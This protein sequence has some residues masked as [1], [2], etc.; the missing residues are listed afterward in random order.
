M[1]SH[2]VV[3]QY[4]SAAQTELAQAPQLDVFSACPAEQ[5]PCAQL[6]PPPPPPPPQVPAPH[7]WV[8]SLT[9]MPS[10]RL[11]QQ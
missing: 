4:G 5:T 9:Q 7:H 8:A 1:L 3:Q 2:S 6:P 10:Q 11:L